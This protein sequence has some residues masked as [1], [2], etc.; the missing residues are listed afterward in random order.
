MTERLHALID[1]AEAERAQRSNHARLRRLLGMLEFEPQVDPRAIHAAVGE[2]LA[3][4]R[5]RGIAAVAPLLARPETAAAA[6][7]VHER[8]AAGEQRTP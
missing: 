4:Q 6:R 7:A 1:E 5:Q 3:D 2:E 8:L